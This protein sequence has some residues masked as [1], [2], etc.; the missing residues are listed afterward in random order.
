MDR[1]IQE[2]RKQRDRAESRIESMLGSVREDKVS[3]PD[4]HLR[5]EST[6]NEIRIDELSMFNFNRH[7]RQLSQTSED[8]F[9]LDNNTPRF[10]DPDTSL[11]W[12]N[13]AQETEPN[14]EEDECKEVRCIEAD[15]TAMDQKRE[16]FD[17][18]I[19]I[20]EEKEG[21]EEHTVPI[22]VAP[23]SSYEALQQ[24]IQYMQRTIN[25]LVNLYPAEESPYHSE[26][27]MS[28]SR[29]S[30]LARSR[31]CRAV[32]TTSNSFIWSKEV[33]HNENTSFAVDSPGS[34][35]NFWWKMPRSGQR[36]N[37]ENLSRKDSHSSTLSVSFDEDEYKESHIEA[38]TYSK[39]SA[40]RARA[41]RDGIAIKRL[42]TGDPSASVVTSPLRA[43]QMKQI[44]VDHNSEEFYGGEKGLRRK[45]LKAKYGAKAG[46]FSRKHSSASVLSAPPDRYDSKDSD[47]EDNV[48]VL[49]FNA[50][51][52]EFFEPHYESQRSE[53]LVRKENRLALFH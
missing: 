24:R 29:G 12:E 48:S 37:F 23:D 40:P 46:R 32:L 20:F 5:S 25:C 2:L 8:S 9:L 31:S 47:S 15:N 43:E 1:E 19:P 10:V 34:V 35:H 30:K 44:G 11:S 33:Q 21:N 14:P 22:P 27:R 50:E 45:L 42:L 7:Q 18:L 41:N 28:S 52:K 39:G 3:K 53:D 38:E 13:I 16:E 6:M 26:A 49:N 17:T 4:E 51:H 36:A